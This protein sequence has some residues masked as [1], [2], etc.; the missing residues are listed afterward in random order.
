M[1]PAHVGAVLVARGRAAEGVDLA[2]HG[3]GAEHYLPVR[4]AG[5]HV[6]AGRAEDGPGPVEGHEARELGEAHVE[7][8]AKA[9]PP[10][11]GVEADDLVAG[12]ESVTLAEML[13]AL[14]RDV[15]EVALAAPGGLAALAVED[16]A[17]VIEPAVRALR[18]RAAYE[19]D[20][21]FPRRGAEHGPGGAARGLLMG[22][23]AGVFILAAEHLRQADYVRAAARGLGNHLPGVG[24][25]AL[26]V[27]GGGELYQCGFHRRG[28][29]FYKINKL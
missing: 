9:E 3:A 24:E 23:K 21:V 7:A 15:E 8:D 26:L 29:L 19:P 10:E 1:R 11:F 12:R 4:R 16:K 20:A 17:G 13:P 6:E 2:L 18:Y 5:G 25:V 14:D 27:A 22:D 28:L